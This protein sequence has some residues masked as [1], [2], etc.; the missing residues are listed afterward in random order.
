MFSDVCVV[1][2]ARICA[3][4][5]FSRDYRDLNNKAVADYSTKTTSTTVLL[6][7]WAGPPGKK[8]GKRIHFA[9][10]FSN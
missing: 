10:H 7:E 8:E 6:G 9:V 4:N 1:L 3:L 2:D 5:F